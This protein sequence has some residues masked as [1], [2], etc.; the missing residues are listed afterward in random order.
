MP[1]PRRPSPS[2]FIC[3]NL[4][5]KR[6]QSVYKQFLETVRDNLYG[7]AGLGK[8][9]VLAESLVA[10]FYSLLWP[11]LH[12]SPVGPALPSHQRCPAPHPSYSLCWLSF[13][14]CMP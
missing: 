12:M 4:I 7:H 13:V 11:S 9:T 1:S 10:V 3:V 2:Y 5:N 14:S 6:I 8:F